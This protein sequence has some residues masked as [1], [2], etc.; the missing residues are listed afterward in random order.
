M[1]ESEG[2]FLL[3]VY[4]LRHLLHMIVSKAIGS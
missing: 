1:I 4:V 2:N 3:H